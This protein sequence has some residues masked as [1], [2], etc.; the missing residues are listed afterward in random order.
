MTV[1]A[2][3]RESGCVVVS[4][5]KPFDGI[6]YIDGTQFKIVRITAHGITN[7][8]ELVSPT[9]YFRSCNFNEP[10]SLQIGGTLSNKEILAEISK[11]RF[12]ISNIV[13]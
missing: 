1:S 4:I 7:K 13:Q 12:L 8:G 10:A 9:V 3:Y 2:E 5:D 6:F 11:S